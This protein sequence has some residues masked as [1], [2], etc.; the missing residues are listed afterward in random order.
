M[1]K[2][3]G[4][5]V[6]E[7]IREQRGLA[8]AIGKELGISRSAVWMWRKV[9]AQH[10]IKVAKFLGLPRYKVRPDLYPYP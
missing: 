6:A 4:N 8:A 10:A 9:P 5:P 7:M 3:E 2:A 1:P